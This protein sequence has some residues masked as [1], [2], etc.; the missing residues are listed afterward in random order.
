[1]FYFYKL[2][3]CGDFGVAEFEFLTKSIALWHDE[4]WLISEIFCDTEKCGSLV[5]GGIIPELANLS[6]KDQKNLESKVNW[7]NEKK[8]FQNKSKV[9]DPSYKKTPNLQ[10]NSSSFEGQ[11]TSQNLQS[12]NF[13]NLT[14]SNQVLQN[15]NNSNSGTNFLSHSDKSQGVSN[16]LQNKPFKFQNQLTQKVENQGQNIQ[17]KLAFQAQEFIVKLE[18]Y[19]IQNTP[20]KLLI[21]VLSKS[22]DSPKI[23]QIGKKAKINKLNLIDKLPNFGHFKASRSQLIILNNPLN[24]HFKNSS[25]FDNS[26]ENNFQNQHK[27]AILGSH[28]FLLFEVQTFADQEYWANLD[29]NLT[30]EMSRGLMNLKLARTLLNLSDKTTVWDPFC[31]SGRTMAAG[32]KNFIMSDLES[33]C[34]KEVLTNFNFLEKQKSQNS[35]K[36]PNLIQIENSPKTDLDKKEKLEFQSQV[37]TENLENLEKNSALQNLENN[38]TQNPPFLAKIPSNNLSSKS[39]L[40]ANFTMDATILTQILTIPEFE[41]Q[42]WLELAPSIAIIT[43]GWLGQN[44]KKPPNAVEIKEQF[45]KLEKIWQKVLWESARLKI[46]EII[47]CLPFYPIFNSQMKNEANNSKVNSPNSNKFILPPFINSIL[48]NSKYQIVE[49]AGQKNLLYH[50]KDSLVGHLVIKLSLKKD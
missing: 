30:G 17:N 37:K 1:M 40:L 33:Q 45:A 18:K 36:N 25:H 16:S 24:S 31:G 11:Q 27:L 19:L 32:L 39:K 43:E 46:E 2:G 34:A 14:H 9:Y 4:N 35:P 20:K 15:Q 13:K 50:R 10:K 38:Q 12:P 41:N 3:H 42:N 22:F 47:F 28:P 5:F 49:L 44:F 26:V 48:G 23:F 7:Q 6:D 8:I 21:S 29:Q